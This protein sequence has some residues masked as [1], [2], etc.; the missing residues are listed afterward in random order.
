[1]RGLLL[2]PLLVGWLSRFA[3]GQPIDEKPID[4]GSRLEWFA[5]GRLVGHLEGAVFQLH[6]PQPAGVAL[7]FD[8]AWEGAFSG[9][10]TVIR[11]EERFRMYYRGLPVAG[12]DGSTN[13]VTCYAESRD[14]LAWIKPRLGLFE[15]AGTRENNVVLAHQAP[16]SH[17]FAPFLDARPGIPAEERY[18][19]LAGTSATGLHA[20]VSG[21]GLRW[22]RWREQP[23]LTRGA[24]DS[25]NVGFWSSAEG[26]YVI[27]FRTWT[28]G[29]FEGFRTVSRTTSTHFS[30]WSSPQEM[31][32]GGAPLEH[33]YT[34]QTHPYF[35][36]PHLYVATPMRFIPGRRVLTEEQERVLG[37]KPGY[38]GDV[39]ETVFMTSRGGTR[40]DRLFLEGFIRPG[41]D[42]GNWASRAGLSALGIVPTGP[43]EMS[44][45]KQA[46][47]A[48]PDCQLLRY[49]LRTDGFVSVRAPFGGGEMVTRPLRFAGREMILNFATGAAGGV[50]VEIQDQAGTAVPG[51]SL[52][53]SV[54]QVGDEIERRVRWK[55]GSDVGA[56]A[57]R[58]VR[59]RFAMKDADLYSLRFR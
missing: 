1:M 6:S 25:Q 49:T 52:G 59:L 36:A 14:G 22:R 40:Y 37:V 17:N 5:D 53:D 43:A 18:K 38:A 16:F 35:R 39:A 44:L 55:A 10:V 33:L 51:F 31:T 45:F 23:L 50:R 27:Y 42:L 20:F 54:E 12:Q 3:H 2:L 41:P 13:E 32:F 47:Y 56:L 19:A 29:D 58:V 9:Y 30:D 26:C 8:E 11:D 7:R 21:D 24:F 34:S 4:I 15:V 48:Q 46:H 57:D 28:K